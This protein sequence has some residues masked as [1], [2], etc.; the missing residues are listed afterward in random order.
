MIDLGWQDGKRKRK[1][2]YARTR[3][4]AA[5]KMPTP[6]ATSAKGG[7]SPTSAPPSN[8]TSGPGWR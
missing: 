2:V 3:A 4:E 1:F 5:R 8:S 6:N 7:S